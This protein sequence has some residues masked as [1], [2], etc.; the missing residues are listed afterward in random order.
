VKDISIIRRH[1]AVQTKEAFSH[2]NETKHPAERSPPRVVLLTETIEKI[3][4]GIVIDQ[5]TLAPTG[6]GNRG[7]PPAE[8]PFR[9]CASLP[10]LHGIVVSDQSQ[11][12]TLLFALGRLAE[13]SHARCS[14]FKRSAG[15]GTE[16][17]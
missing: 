3:H 17:R 8:E 13:C 16:T 11:G 10:G 14:W 7:T 4:Q 5:K 12:K 1:S 2:E 15:F 9:A 6:F